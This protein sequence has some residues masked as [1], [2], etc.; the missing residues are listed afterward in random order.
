[1]SG[2]GRATP[3]AI[4]DAPVPA[5]SAHPSH[6]KP[7]PNYLFKQLAETYYPTECSLRRNIGVIKQAVI[8]PTFFKDMNKYGR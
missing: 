5:G 8:K 6:N 4:T 1:M 3:G 2:G 7:P